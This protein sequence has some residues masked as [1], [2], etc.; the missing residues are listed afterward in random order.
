MEGHRP[1]ILMW[2]LT[3]AC[4][5]SCVH[6]A[7]GSLPRRAPV[8]L[9]TY[10]AYKTLD[11]IVAMQPEELVITGGDPL[12]RSDI[13]QL[14]DYARRRGLAPSLAAAMTPLLNGSS[15]GKLKLNGLQ[16]LILGL[17]SSA[18]D[19]ND[20]ERGVSGQFAATLMAARWARTANLEIE[21]NTLISRRNIDDLASLASLLTQLGAVRWNVY[22]LVPLGESRH[23][24]VLSGAEAEGVLKTLHSLAERVPFPIRLFEAPQ[25]RDFE[26]PDMLYISHS[27]EVSL[28]PFLPVSVGNIRYQPLSSIDQSSE[29]LLAIRDERNLRGKC[30]RCEYRSRCGGSRAR[31]YTTTG[32]VFA[33]DPLCSYQPGEHPELK[34]VALPVSSRGGSA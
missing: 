20:Q 11:Q 31:A 10:E 18:P 13:Y 8:E 5:V 17:D 32:D 3:R 25:Y 12:E 6:C 9:S 23:V 27:G 16:R 14:I 33:T 26:R 1:R 7:I 22:F 29:M 15:V 2:E 30:A 28:S 4:K 21:V 19:R 34:P 24:E